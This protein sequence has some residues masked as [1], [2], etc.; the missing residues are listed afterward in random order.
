MEHLNT[1]A[2][3]GRHE[4]SPGRKPWEGFKMIIKPRRGGTDRPTGQKDSFDLKSAGAEARQNK[5]D[6]ILNR[7]RGPGSPAL[8][9]IATRVEFF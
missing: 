8:P 5:P 6:K 3:E 2:P 7:L 1:R 4:G 9:R